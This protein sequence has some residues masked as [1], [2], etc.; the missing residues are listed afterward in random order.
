MLFCPEC[1]YVIMAFLFPYEPVG[2]V[3]Q[4]PQMAIYLPRP[5]SSYR[6]T[7][8]GMGADLWLDLVFHSGVD[9]SP[10]LVLLHLCVGSNS[11]FWIV[12]SLTLVNP[13]SV[14]TANSQMHR[15]NWSLVGGGGPLL[16]GYG[17]C[18]RYAVLLALLTHHF[19]AANRPPLRSS[20]P[21]LSD[22]EASIQGPLR[23]FTRGLSYP[24]RWL[25]VC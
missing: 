13:I 12:E 5:A 10:K 16:A 22:L 8:E 2:F 1:F 7:I 17:W 11:I 24:E 3:H 23:H 15:T 20:I 9:V 4:S 6:S 19:V 21:C 18:H 25:V 14:C